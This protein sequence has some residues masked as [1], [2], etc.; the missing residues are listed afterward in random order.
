MNSFSLKEDSKEECLKMCDAIQFK[1]SPLFADE[2]LSSAG[3]KRHTMASLASHA[4][5]CATL[6]D[7]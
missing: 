3:M 2:L 5:V 7:P 4:V 1:K 6:P